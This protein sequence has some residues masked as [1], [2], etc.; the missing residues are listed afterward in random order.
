MTHEKF[1]GTMNLLSDTFGRQL[2]E[3][4]LEGYWLALRY[5]PDDAMPAA[6][7]QV[8]GSCKFMPAPAQLVEFAGYNPAKLR[9]AEEDR[10]MAEHT[11][12]LISDTREAK[13]RRMTPEEMEQ[14]RKD[15]RNLAKSKAVEE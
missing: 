1:V 11:G 5:V 12:R 14:M 3:G 15:I 13:S 2:T 4:A 7:V 9:K 8:M 6:I 10:R